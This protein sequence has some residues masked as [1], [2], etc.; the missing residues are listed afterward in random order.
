MPIG[1]GGNELVGIAA[2]GSVAGCDAQIVQGREHPRAGP[3]QSRVGAVAE[4]AGTGEDHPEQDAERRQARAQRD[5]QRLVGSSCSGSALRATCSVSA[6]SRSMKGSRRDWSRSAKVTRRCWNCGKAFSA[7][8]AAWR[9]SIGAA[10]KMSADAGGR[11]ENQ[12]QKS[13]GADHAAT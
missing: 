6:A 10:G 2:D 9:G 7:V 12:K 13:A 5:Q 1:H 11:G 8:C 4:V 3:V